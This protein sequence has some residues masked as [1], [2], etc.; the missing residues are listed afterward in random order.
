[1]RNPFQVVYPGMKPK[2]ARRFLNRN[3]LKIARARS[4]GRSNSLTFRAYI[5][6]KVLAKEKKK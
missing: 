1:M 6:E 5:A 3:K 4:Y 2:T